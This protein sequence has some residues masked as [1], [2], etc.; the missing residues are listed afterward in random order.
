[1]SLADLAQRALL[2]TERGAAAVVDADLATLALADD[3]ALTL[4]RQA[5]WAAVRERAGGLHSAEN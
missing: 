4:L 5:A 1:M 3:A 2:G